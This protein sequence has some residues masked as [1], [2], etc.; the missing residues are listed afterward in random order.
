MK[1]LEPRH[2]ALLVVALAFFTDTLVYAMLPPLLPE[3]ARLHGLS[4]TRLG[5]LY[6]SYAGALLLTS[7][8]LGAWADRHGR[9]GPFLAGLAGFG[10]ATV[11]FAFADSFPLLVLSRILQGSAASATWVSGLALLADHYPAGRRG[12]AMSLVFAGANLG[13]LAGPSFSGWMV[14]LWSIRAA[15]L[16][17]AGLALLDALVRV[18]LLPGDPPASAPGAGYW[19]LL[20]AGRVRV[21]AGAM[22]MGAALG[23]VLEAVLPLRMERSLGMSAPMVGLA[24]TLAALASTFTSPFVGHWT[25]RAGADRPLRLGLVLAA[26]VLAAAPL[27][28]GQASMGLLMLGT[29]A[30]SSLLMS[31]CGPALAAHVEASGE[32]EFGSVFSLLNISFALG[33]MLG[34]MVGSWLTD[35]AGLGAA[36]G[37]LAGAFL[38]YPAL[39]R[40]GG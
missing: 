13:L 1:R 30:T 19:G 6:G 27:I 36:M 25:D 23:S 2:A 35:E 4:Q 38:L 7:I 3:Y 17:A 15:F 32:K 31:P 12:R 5:F 33:M 28:P 40:R 18:T 10:A 34:P 16:A 9:R 29:G 26:V 20:R 14:R 22:A 39:L 24:F 11:L 8:P 21:L 37:I